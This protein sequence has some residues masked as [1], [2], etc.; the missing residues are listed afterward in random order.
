MNRMNGLR[1]SRAKPTLSSRRVAA[2]GDHSTMFYLSFRQ[3]CNETPFSLL[4]RMVTNAPITPHV[5]TGHRPPAAVKKNPKQ[6]EQ[7]ASRR[8]FIVVLFSESL[9]RTLSSSE[10]LAIAEIRR[11]WELAKGGALAAPQEL[12]RCV[13]VDG[14]VEKVLTNC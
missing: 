3:H 14:A 1:A 5:A 6:S 10:T 8:F 11:Q 7:M 12:N 9:L 4:L 2:A 13:P